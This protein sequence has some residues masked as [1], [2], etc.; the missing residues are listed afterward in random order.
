MIITFALYNIIKIAKKP[1]KDNDNRNKFELQAKILE[2]DSNI[3]KQEEIS[4]N[5]I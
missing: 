5:R 1:I 3:I 4:G 2:Q